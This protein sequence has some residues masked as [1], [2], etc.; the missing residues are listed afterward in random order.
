MPGIRISLADVTAALEAAA[1]SKSLAVAVMPIEEENPDAKK[2]TASVVF[3]HK[4]IACENPVPPVQISG[5]VEILPVDESADGD[6]EQ[7]T[8]LLDT[9]TM[10]LTTSDVKRLATVMAMNAATG[11][12][13]KQK[14]MDVSEQQQVV[15]KEKMN[16]EALAEKEPELV[17]KIRAGALLPRSP[18]SGGSGKQN[19][20]ASPDDEG[21]GAQ[22]SSKE[23]SPRKRNTTEMGDLDQ[24]TLETQDGLILHQE[25]DTVYAVHRMHFLDCAKDPRVDKRGAHNPVTT[26]Y[27]GLPGRPSPDYSTPAMLEAEAKTQQGAQHHAHRGHQHGTAS[28][29]GSK[30]P[31]AATSPGPHGSPSSSRGPAL[32]PGS[33]PG[34]HRGSLRDHLRVTVNVSQAGS[35]HSEAHGNG[36]GVVPD[37]LEPLRKLENI[38]TDEF[39]DLLFQVL[40]AADEDSEG[41]LPIRDVIRTLEA[42]FCSKGGLL[43]KWDITVLM[44]RLEDRVDADGMARYPRLITEMRAPS[45]SATEALNQSLESPPSELAMALNAGA[46]GNQQ[47]GNYMLPIPEHGQAHVSGNSE[48]GGTTGTAPEQDWHVVERV[49]EMVAFVQNY[50]VNTLHDLVQKKCEPFAEASHPELLKRATLRRVLD[51]LH[52][53]IS[54]SEKSLLMQVMPMRVLFRTPAELAESNAVDINAPPMKRKSTINLPEAPSP[55]DGAGGTPSG[56]TF[57]G[58]TTSDGQTKKKPAM[59]INFTVF[60][61]NLSEIRAARAVNFPGN[62]M[63]MEMRKSMCALARQ[64]RMPAN[65]PL[66]VFRE[67]ILNPLLKR[68]MVWL[69]SFEIF[70]LG[71]VL[72]PAVGHRVPKGYTDVDL[73]SLIVLSCINTWH[74][75]H[76]VYNDGIEQQMEVEA[77]RKRKEMEELQ[78]FSGA[79]PKDQSGGASPEDQSGGAKAAIHLRDNQDQ[80]ERALLASFTVVDSERTGLLEMPQIAQT[81]LGDW[82][83]YCDEGGL[84]YTE[85]CGLLAACEPVEG[86][87]RYEEHVKTWMSVV[88]D[89]RQNATYRQLLQVESPED[90]LLSAKL[91]TMRENF[92]MTVVEVPAKKRTGTGSMVVAGRAT[93]EDS[94]RKTSVRRT[95]VHEQPKSR[96]GKLIQHSRVEVLPAMVNESRSDRRR[97]LGEESWSLTVDGSTGA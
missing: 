75:A 36:S 86:L 68:K 43:T 63:I 70:L 92:P 94:E 37:P 10:R 20:G 41:V 1:Q 29:K 47:S 93:R 40:A 90:E 59:F 76:Q 42:V 3:S 69:S 24:P 77:E 6:T 45:S 58:T 50:E 9:Q 17:S 74:D 28:M 21:D 65:V 72:P 16:L 31:S 12:K 35:E 49:Q 19:S 82:D 7:V 27:H 44:A 18:S 83:N 15:I 79:S 95:R 57:G 55:G 91:V 64:E 60:K 33:S 23:Q 25:G 11:I 81:I 73:A 8:F 97:R 84:L 66:H 56:V 71:C 67:K 61:D 38:P 2:K 5:A 14:M 22:V 52:T 54:E 30:A 78:A 13:M 34:D 51:S 32:S 39:Q 46:I 80:V 53:R 62:I 4:Q 48:G 96:G 85:K 26:S 89:I 88:F 87:V